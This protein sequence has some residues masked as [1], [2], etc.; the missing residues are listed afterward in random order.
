MALSTLVI[1]GTPRLSSYCTGNAIG[2]GD[3]SRDRIVPDFMAAIKK[4]RPLYVRNPDAVRPWQHVLEPLS[5]YLLLAEKL[6]DN[7]SQYAEGWNFG[8]APDDIRPVR[9]IV[10]K[11][12]DYW[13][14]P[15]LWEI[16]K[17]SKPHEAHLL[18]L[19]SAKSRMML[20]WKPRWTAALSKTRPALLGRTRPVGGRDC[21]Q[22]CA[23]DRASEG[24][25][26]PMRPSAMEPTVIGR[27]GWRSQ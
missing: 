7:P 21:A 24:G 13:D 22:N 26:R 5:G 14:K 10:E 8:P 6:W 17:A 25:R 2:G 16:D 3:F 19:D 23:H 12:N 15:I 4:G 11:L 27:V 9:W 20:G 1:Q 18:V